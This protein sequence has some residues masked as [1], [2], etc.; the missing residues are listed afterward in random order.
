MINVIT[1][2]HPDLMIL[3]TPYIWHEVNPTQIPDFIVNLSIDL[4]QF[5]MNSLLGTLSVLIGVDIDVS[6]SE[7]KNCVNSLLCIPNTSKFVCSTLNI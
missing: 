6:P 3:S 4:V 2:N 7:T 1:E 5:E